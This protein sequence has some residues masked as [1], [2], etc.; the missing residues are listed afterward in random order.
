M[1]TGRKN[2]VSLTAATLL[3]KM[4]ESVSLW[5]ILLEPDHG[6]E[7]VNVIARVL[8]KT[9]ST[10]IYVLTLYESDFCLCGK[11]C[12]AIYVWTCLLSSPFSYTFLAMILATWFFPVPEVPCKERTS[13][14]FGL[15]S[16]INVDTAL[17]ITFDAMCCPKK[18]SLKSSAKPERCEDMWSW[19][20]T[21]LW[22]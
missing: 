11:W 8:A 5:A 21:M 2:A 10:T 20:I 4:S 18:F 3:Y 19:Q 14:L 16:V 9:K 17:S 15:L 6:K 22:K 12:I 1:N 13:G 7:A